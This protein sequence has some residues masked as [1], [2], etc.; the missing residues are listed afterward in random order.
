MKRAVLCSFSHPEP[1]RQRQGVFPIFLP[2]A[3]C[4]IRCVFC[5]QEI[6]TGHVHTSLSVTLY[7]AAQAL[8][9]RV[10]QAKP[11]VELAFYG[12]TFTALPQEEQHAC[13]AFA[14]EWRRRGAVNRIRCSTRPD[15]VDEAALALLREGGVSLVELG[16]QSFSDAALA[17]SGRGYDGKTAVQG[18]GQ[19]LRGGLALGIQLM[20]GM[21]GLTEDAARLDVRTAVAFPLTALRLYPCLVLRGT[22]LERLWQ[23]G[24]FIPWPLDQ[25]ESFLADACLAAWEK[26]IPVIRMGLAQERGLTEN[27]LAGPWHPAIGSMA[28]GLALFRYIERTLREARSGAA[29]ARERPQKPLPLYVRAPRRCQ[30]EFWGQGGALVEKYAALG[31]TPERVTWTEEGEFAIREGEPTC[32]STP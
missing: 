28:R 2:F 14:G 12:G 31:I 6:Q 21:P 16:I 13:L 1:V 11:P 29:D 26:G 15:A 24:E 17:A 19:V 3:G 8:A 25:T 20:P 22:G 23:S 30:G 10:E 9:Q 7:R 27:I 18:C 5:A 32:S 4:K